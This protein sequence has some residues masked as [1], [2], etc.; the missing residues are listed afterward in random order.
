MHGIGAFRDALDEKLD[1]AR[2]ACDAIGAMPGVEI[3][4][5]PELSLFVFRVGPSRGESAAELD[6]R[7]RRL[8]R[9]INRRQRVFVTGTMVHGRFV[10]RACVLSFRTHADRIAMLIDDVRA[11]LARVT[12]QG[13]AQSPQ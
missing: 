1:R 2:E 3:V 10:V 4:A 8:L 6:A 9:E 7:D 13:R 11:A 12:P 5:E